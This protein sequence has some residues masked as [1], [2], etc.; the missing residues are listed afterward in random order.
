MIIGLHL[1]FGYKTREIAQFMELNDNTVR[2]KE[3]RAMKKLEN[4][5]KG[6]RENG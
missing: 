3:S 4:K 6:L 1:F 2:S 5:L